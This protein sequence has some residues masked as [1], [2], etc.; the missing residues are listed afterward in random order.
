MTEN[1]NEKQE[2]D[3][4][5]VDEKSP[6]QHEKEEKYSEK[7]TSWTRDT[8]SGTVWALA[9]IWAGVVF[10]I[11]S[12]NMKFFSWLTWGSYA[13]GIVLLG[14]ALL[15]GLEIAIRLMVPKYAAPVRGRIILALILAFI[16]LSNLAKVS[17]LPILLIAIGLYILFGVFRPRR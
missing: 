13:W 6:A 12:L 5:S 4:K 17:L 14:V 2:K 15:L 8:L 9:L 7:S 16:G 11:V 3:E 1:H 10:L